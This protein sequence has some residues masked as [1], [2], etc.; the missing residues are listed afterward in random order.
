MNRREK[1]GWRTL[2]ERRDRV[3]VGKHQREKYRHPE[4]QND[5]LNVIGDDDGPES[6]HERVQ[7]HNTAAYHYACLQVVT[8]AGGH[9]DAGGIDLQPIVDNLER[10]ARPGDCLTDLPVV[11]CFQKLGWTDDA[12]AAPAARQE[13]RPHQHCHGGTPDQGQRNEAVAVRHLG[14]SNKG[15]RAEGGEIE[16]NPSEPPRDRIAPGEKVPYL[17]HALPEVNAD[18]CQQNEVAGNDQMVGKMERLMHDC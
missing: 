6:A 18:G 7:H 9:K 8:E 2:A 11:T 5:E 12:G 3:Q 17:A 10:K 1:A 13:D 4:S 16:R 15:E 14:V